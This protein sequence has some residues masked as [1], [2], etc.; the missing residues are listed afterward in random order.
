MTTEYDSVK[1]SGERRD[2]GTGSVRDVRTGKGRFDLLPPV[3]LR[4]LARHVENGAVKY[5]D[6]NWEKGQPL[7]SYL[8]SMMRHVVNMMALDVDEDHAAAVA[9]NAMAFMSTVEWIKDGTLPRDLDDIGYVD[10]LEEV[11]E[12]ASLPYDEVSSVENGPVKIGTLTDVPV[13]EYDSPKFW[14]GMGVQQV[15]IAGLS[16]DDV[17][18]VRRAQQEAIDRR[19]TRAPSA[20][21][22]TCTPDCPLY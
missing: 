20:A 17:A 13:F 1:D 22:H 4:R 14:D 19:D 18:A 2:F 5:G 6:R 3:F 21:D 8:D 9:W 10:H 16:G 12:D 15:W 7:G 11:E